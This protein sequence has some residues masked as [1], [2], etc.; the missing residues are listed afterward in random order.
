MSVRIVRLGSP[1]LR[2]EGTRLGTVRRPPRGVRREDYA[3][4][5]YYDVWLPTLAP[6]PD[7]VKL[8]LTATSA[9]DLATFE[10]RYRR[11]MAQGEAR[12]VLDTLA[13]LSHSTD[14]SVGCY[15]A[16]ESRCHRRILRELLR[17]RGASLAEGV[18]AA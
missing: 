15:C 17:E 2:G 4:R 10:R 6:A 9:R 13:A 7:T 14:F 3:A 11:E 8:A 16:D 18:D 5:D 12:H 1:R